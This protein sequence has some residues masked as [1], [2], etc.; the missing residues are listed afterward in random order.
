MSYTP[1]VATTTEPVDSRPAGSA[2]AEFRA[3]KTKIAELGDVDIAFDLRL[4]ALE[5]GGGGSGT[6]TG[7]NSL[8]G[9]AVYAS[10]TS[11]ELN[12]RGLTAGQ[13]V[14]LSASGTAITISS[15]VISSTDPGAVGAGVLWVQP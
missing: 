10:E 14:A 4:D 11:G 3:I 7:A 5:M 15:V 2:A 9:T 13:G 8:G 1:N 6:I 12:F